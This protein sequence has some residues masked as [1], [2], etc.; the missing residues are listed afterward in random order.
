MNI[1]KD[2]QY[3][4][5]FRHTC[6]EETTWLHLSRCP[7]NPSSSQLIRAHVPQ[8]LRGYVHDISTSVCH[9]AR[10]A[11]LKFFFSFSQVF[12]TRTDVLQCVHEPFG[13]AF[14]FGPERLSD[15]YEND[16]EA[17]KESGFENSTFKTI[18]DRLDAESTE[19]RNSRQHVFFGSIVLRCDQRPVFISFFYFLISILSLFPSFSISQHKAG[20]HVH[21]A[22]Q[23]TGSS[24]RSFTMT[25]TCACSLAPN[26]MRF[27]TPNR[28]SSSTG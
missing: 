12:M 28:H 15:R 14:Y 20:G 18:F 6:R 2:I 1:F 7:I 3:T 22:F 13:D 26:S 23:Y 21:V 27:S 11:D 5:T 9:E 17:R 25:I 4:Y 24:I 10:L 8:L 16:E 19:V